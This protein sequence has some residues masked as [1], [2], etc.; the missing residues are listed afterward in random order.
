MAQVAI[1]QGTD[2]SQA[3]HHP[4]DTEV[5]EREGLIFELSSDNL[6]IP[7]LYT[8][9]VAKGNAATEALA[10]N[11]VVFCEPEWGLDATGLGGGNYVGA[12]PMGGPSGGMTVAW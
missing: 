1:S 4:F 10:R 2:L 6:N 3:G 12:G 11:A 8:L 9:A 7:W 5:Y